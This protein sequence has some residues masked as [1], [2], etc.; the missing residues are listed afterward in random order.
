MRRSIDPIMS[1]R[2]EAS[3]IP[4]VHIIPVVSMPVIFDGLPGY[5]LNKILAM[6]AM[7]STVTLVCFFMHG[8]IGTTRL[9]RAISR[10]S[11]CW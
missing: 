1:D 9:A 11:I 4:L 5:E 6:I 3:I 7:W 2:E 8:G 10:I